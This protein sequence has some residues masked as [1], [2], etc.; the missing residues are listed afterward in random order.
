MIVLLALAPEVQPELLDGLLIRNTIYDKIFT[1]F[2]GVF[3]RSFN[4]FI[5]TL[6]TALFILGGQQLSEQ[7]KFMALFDKNGKLY[8]TNILKDIKAE[9]G[10]PVCHRHLALSENALSQ[11]LGGKDVRYEYCADFPARELTTLMDW[12]DL[13]LHESTAIQLKELLAWSDYGRKLIDELTM[14]IKVA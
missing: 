6:K 9:K 12:D 10:N 11:I 14:A 7:I 8:G 5:P 2:G 4:G 1:E 3:T 13:V